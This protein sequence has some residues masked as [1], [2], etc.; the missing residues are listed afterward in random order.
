MRTITESDIQDIACNYAK[1]LCGRKPYVGL[2]YYLEK[3]IADG[4]KHLT[5]PQ[6]EACI[7]LAAK[8][9]IRFGNAQQRLTRKPTR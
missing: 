8:V 5:T 4:Y 2:D 9:L 3:E 7:A 1:Y 6:R